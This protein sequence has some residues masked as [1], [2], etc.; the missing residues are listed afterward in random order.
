MTSCRWSIV[1]RKPPLPQTHVATCQSLVAKNLLGRA[2]LWRFFAVRGPAPRLLGRGTLPRELHG[3]APRLLGRLLDQVVDTFV[4]AF[5][6]SLL[7][8][9]RARVGNVF[10]DT[11]LDTFLRSFTNTS[12]LSV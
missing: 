9:V 4:A 8:T 10:L 12:V 1:K 3:P 7:D 11:F 2:A 6:E 5:P